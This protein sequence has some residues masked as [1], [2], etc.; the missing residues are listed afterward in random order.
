MK[1]HTGDFRYEFRVERHLGTAVTSYF[2]DFCV[3]LNEDGTTTLSGLVIDQ[4]ALHGV[5]ARIRDLGL[6]LI[7]VS[8]VMVPEKVQPTEE[9]IHV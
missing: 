4:A 6:T 9:Q 1:T 2:P 7:A 8:R 3:M 5:L